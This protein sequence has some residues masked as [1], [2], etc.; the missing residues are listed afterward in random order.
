MPLL[1]PRE[2]DTVYLAV[3]DGETTRLLFGLRLRSPSL[4]QVF[5]LQILSRAPDIGRWHGLGFQPSK[6]DTGWAEALRQRKLPCC[7]RRVGC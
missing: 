1:G 3:D 6:S 2:L 5:G 7:P 4:Q